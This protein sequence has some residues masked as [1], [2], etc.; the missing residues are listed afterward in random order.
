MQMPQ[1]NE[2]TMLPFFVR[3]V[4]TLALVLTLFLTARPDPAF[5]A[6]QESP[7]QG[8]ADSNAAGSN[9][10]A[11][12]SEAAEAWDAVKDT[13]NP[14]LLEAFIKRFGTTFF[15]ELAKARLA[16]L[17]TAAVKARPSV[18]SLAPMPNN[19]VREH[20]A[21]YEE[22]MSDAKGRRFEGSVIWH[23][24]KIKI[25]G[26]PDELAARADLEIPSRGLRMTMSLK[27]NLDSALPAS[28]L[29]ELTIAVS[30]D[31]DG[32]GVA[33]V[34]GIMMK[35]NEQAR[36]S[37]LAGLSVKVTDGFF[38]DGL[39]ATTSDR[40]RNLKLLLERQWFDIPIVYAS[41]RRAILAIEKGTT[42]DQVFKTVFTAWG[43]YPDSTQPEAATSEESTRDMPEE[44]KRS[45]TGRP[46]A[47]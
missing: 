45:M 13:T 41:Q 15:A 21:L 3:L 9:G 25:N 6:S 44:W 43:Q 2:W 4:A 22:D 37:P 7:E 8:A 12:K 42:G 36:G 27:R 29:V 26:K 34:P 32:G 35:A 11:P 1:Q 31:F 28:H 46:K 16:E 19:G 38:L 24:E 40:E 23:T 5:A 17:K 18:P 33:N 47:P 10:A 20:V 39:S 30:G 14:A